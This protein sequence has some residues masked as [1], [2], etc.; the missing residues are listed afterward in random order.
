MPKYYQKYIFLQCHVLHQKTMQKLSAGLYTIKG[1]E[2]SSKHKKICIENS[3]KMQKYY[4]KYIF[5]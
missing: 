1:S 4:Q 2:I 5:L 3:E